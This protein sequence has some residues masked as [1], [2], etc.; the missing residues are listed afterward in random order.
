MDS[1][2]SRII[3]VA[4][5]NDPSHLINSDRANYRSIKSRYIDALNMH[6]YAERI[7]N[8]TLTAPGATDT[9]P[10]AAEW[11]DVNRRIYSSTR[12]LLTDALRDLHHPDQD[13]AVTDG[14]G[15]S[16]WAAL[17]A[18]YGE[19]Q[20]PANDHSLT[21]GQITQCPYLNDR[22]Y[23]PS[24]VLLVLINANARLPAA[25][26]LDAA[27]MRAV[28]LR[29]L[30]PCLETQ[31]LF[32]ERDTTLVTPMLVRDQVE[33]DER[34]FMWLDVTFGLDDVS[35][36]L[37]R[38]GIPAAVA[39][40]QPAAMLATPAPSPP[41]SGQFARLHVCTCGLCTFAFSEPPSSDCVV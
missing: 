35:P 29:I 14:D 17:E 20:T 11:A 12:Q 10:T 21:A 6:S 36:P 32:I 30:P 9:A 26:R 3:S 34:Q 24:T 39:Q 19:A 7:R 38:G 13:P 18:R 22:S 4:Q 8:G 28:F 1:A 2:W 5:Q 15:C 16:L 31:R 33:R 37:R 23:R 40:Q 27:Q 41:E 25:F